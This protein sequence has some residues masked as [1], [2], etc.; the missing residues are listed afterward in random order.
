MERPSFTR[1][2]PARPRQLT[3]S[4]PTTYQRGT[5][6]RQPLLL[7][8]YN[9]LPERRAGDNARQ[10]AQRIRRGLHRFKK[11]VLSKYNE[12][13][14]ERLLASPDAETRQATV[15]A[16]GLIGS[17]RVNGLLAAR[18]HDEDSVVREFADD[19]LWSL[20]FRADTEENNRELQR[21]MR[22]RVNEDS[23]AEILDGYQALIERAPRFAEAYNQRAIVH[24]RLG[25]LAKA[26]S[27]C[28]KVLKLNPYHFGAAS[29]LAQCF[30]KLK[31]L[32]AALRSYRRANRINPNLD[33]VKQ[34]ID[35]LERMLGEKG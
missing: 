31:K 12:A 26:V 25:E 22:L 13:T 32:R 4:V 15:L 23:A 6:V 17:L 5:D 35:S 3:W 8:Y 28:E 20:W 14:L 16:L 9:H 21:L 10:A 2:L 29:G 19:A 24:F 7:E 27:D 11:E 18:L 1:E 33:G 30:M 34:V